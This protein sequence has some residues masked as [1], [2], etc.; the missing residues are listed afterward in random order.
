MSDD[1]D[2]YLWTGQ[3]HVTLEIAELERELRSLRWRSRELSLPDA[4][5]AIEPAKVVKVANETHGW[6]P[7]IAGLLAAAAVLALL[8]W[9]RGSSD[10]PTEPMPTEPT[11]QPSGP[12]AGELVDPFGGHAPTLPTPSSDPPKLVDPFSHEPAPSR[13]ATSPD[14]TDPF[15]NSPIAP[16]PPPP[17]ARKP[18]PSPDL[19]DP[20]GSSKPSKPREPGTLYDPFSGEQKPTPK[21]S[22]DL[23]DPF[24]R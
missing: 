24:G 17:R 3:G 22:P 2:E 14:L 13:P 23:K 18:A 19:K 20:F 21:S 8:V 5:E 16:P 15:Y 12:P 11:V 4:D 1:H 10:S 9:L 7:L 6:S